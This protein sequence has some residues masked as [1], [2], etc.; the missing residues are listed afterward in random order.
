MNNYLSQLNL[1]MHIDKILSE[2][3]RFKSENIVQAAEVNRNFR[4]ALI[5]GGVLSLATISSYI[6]VNMRNKKE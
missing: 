6:F 3:E 5:I 4:L 2:I 1:K